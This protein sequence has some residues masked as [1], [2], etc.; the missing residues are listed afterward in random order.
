MRHIL[1]RCAG[2][3]LAI[4]CV[5]CAKPVGVDVRFYSSKDYNF[6]EAERGD[7]QAI[8]DGTAIEVRRFLPA[9][10]RDLALRVQPSASVIPET[11]ETGYATLPN[12]IG[13][14]VDPKHLGGVGATAQREL[15]ATLFHELHHLV[16]YATA[17]KP[18]SLMDDVVAEGLATVFERDAAGASPPWGVYPQDAAN[19][20]TELSALPPDAEHGYWLTAIHADGRRWIG[21]RA[22]A[23]LADRAIKASGK[24]AAALV[25]ATTREVVEMGTAIESGAGGRERA[26]ARARKRQP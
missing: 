2:T 25:S 21:I 1:S 5:S 22:G 8:A 24:S 14:M 16:R 9:L 3:V 23:Y 20:V 19:W 26:P 11:G 4:V 10:P 13:W 7:I 6:S 15:R 18:E 17:G 12:S